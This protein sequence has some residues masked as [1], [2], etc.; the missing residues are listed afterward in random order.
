MNGM[1]AL[2]YRNTLCYFRDRSS[3]LFS[4]MGVLVVVM[5]YLLFLRNTQ[6]YPQQS[7]QQHSFHS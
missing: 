3:V 4:L 5:I 6:L 2:A 7:H 1:T